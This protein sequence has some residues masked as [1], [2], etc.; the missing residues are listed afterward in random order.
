MPRAPI[1]ERTQV[2]GSVVRNALSVAA[3]GVVGG[4]ALSVALMRVMSSLLGQTPGF[5]PVSYGV[6]AAGVLI[7]A[8]SATLQP[9]YRAATVDPMQVLRSE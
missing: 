9:A 2:L 3:I 7:I 6:A 8:L 4:I 5:D 1:N